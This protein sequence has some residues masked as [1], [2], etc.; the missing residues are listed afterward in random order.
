MH[1]LLTGAPGSSAAAARAAARRAG[2]TVTALVRRTSKR[3]VLEELGVA[4][5]GGRPAHRRGARRGGR[6]RGLRAAP[7]GRHQGP[8]AE[9]LPPGQ[10]ARAPGGWWRPWRAAAHA[11]PGSCTA[12][13]S[14]PRARP[15]RAVPGARRSTPAP[16]SIYGRSKLGGE[17]AVREFADRVPSVIVRPP[18][19]YGPGRQEFLPSMLPMAR[20]GVMLK[21]GFGPKHYSL[22]HV[23]DLCTAL[24]GGHRARP[25]AAH[26]RSG[27]GRVHGSG[28]CFVVA[29]QSVI[30]SSFTR[31]SRS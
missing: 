8:D 10:R 31:R 20:L 3:G 9:E 22:I 14:R 13:R 7:G 23:D 21:S 19:V 1:I 12:R 6:G 27:R 15:F 29:S 4:L 2:H 18:I 5:R 24:L 26:G 11:R 28:S 30:R 16:V 25:D 17:Q